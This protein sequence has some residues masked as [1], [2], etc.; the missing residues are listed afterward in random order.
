MHGNYAQV[1]CEKHFSHIY[2][3]QLQSISFADELDGAFCNKDACGDQ[4][5]FTIYAAAFSH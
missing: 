3:I 5:K 2:F 4:Q 1:R